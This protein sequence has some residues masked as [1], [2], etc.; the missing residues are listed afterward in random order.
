MTKLKPKNAPNKPNPFLYVSLLA[1]SLALFVM[2]FG[3]KSFLKTEEVQEISLSEFME[4]YNK[5]EFKTVE[6]K[7]S[8]IIG[9]SD[10]DTTFKTSKELRANFKDLGLDN[11]DVSTE[12]K[13]N[14]ETS[15]KMWMNF[16]I[17]FAPF[18]LLIVLFVFLAR[19]SAGMGDGGPFGFGKSKAKPYDKEKHKT[20]FD[21]VAGSE[22]AKEE[23]SEIVDFLKNPQKYKKA[24]AKLPCGVLMAGAP[25]TGKTLLARAIAG[26]ADVPFFSVSGSEFEEMF[27]GVGASR[28]RDL[29]KTA[30]Q[31]APS[32]I[33]I[34]EIDAI[35][36]QRGD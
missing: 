16:L 8:E 11:K 28:V 7:E 9:M 35:G 3:D 27:V 4:K 5:D 19:R 33:F 10:A 26:E 31:N 13:V 34:D 29:F 17:G 30:K 18:L 32:I 14:N 24:G 25:G 20:K 21:D 15:K 12:V 22:E 6:I 23:V 2:F 1:L 36:K